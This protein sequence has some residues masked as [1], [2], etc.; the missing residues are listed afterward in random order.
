MELVLG[1]NKRS[2][3]TLGRN[4]AVIVGVLFLMMVIMPTH[5]DR[6]PVFTEDGSFQISSQEMIKHF[7]TSKWKVPKHEL[8]DV[9]DFYDYV[10]NPGSSCSAYALLGGRACHEIEDHVVCFDPSLNL[11]HENCLVYSFGMQSNSFEE[12]MINFGCHVYTFDA[13]G[14]RSDHRRGER[15][16]LY[17]VRLAG[18][19][20]AALPGDRVMTLPE[21]M[22]AFGHRGRRVD[23]LKLDLED[24]E[25]WSA[26]RKMMTTRVLDSVQQLAVHVSA[27]VHDLTGRERHDVLRRQYEVLVGLEHSGLRLVSSRPDREGHCKPLPEMDPQRAVCEYHELLYVRKPDTIV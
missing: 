10:E 13:S 23:Y 11:D 14:A 17:R 2:W 20:S 6:T 8:T 1:L 16:F 22:R 26:L 7:K 5:H 9:K 21:V 27:I 12:A 15:S 25:E 3:K 19:D 4:T 24:G 18:N